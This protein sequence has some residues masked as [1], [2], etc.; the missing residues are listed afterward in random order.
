MS[1]SIAIDGPSGAG[2]S[3]VADELASNLQILHLDTGAMYRAFAWQALAEGID[4]LDEAALIKLIERV[5]I[6]IKFED[7]KQ[8][9]LVNG[10]DVTSLIRTPEISMAASN[11]SRLA[12]V[13]HRMVSLQQAL[14]KT[15][16]MVLDGRD[17]GTR[18]LPDATLKVFLTASPEVRA[19]RRFEE[20]KAKGEATTYQEVLDDVRR[21]DL[22][23]S[24]REVDPLRPAE[25][26][27]IVDNSQL[28]QSQTVEAILVHL[29]KTM[30]SAQRVSEM[31]ELK[32]KLEKPRE[33]P[34]QMPKERISFLYKL[35]IAVASVLF[36]TLFPVRYFHAEKAQL[37]AP[38][39]LIANH[40]SMIDPMI[41]GWKC[42]RYQLRFF[43]KKEL[44]QNPILK[45]LFLGLRM[46]PVDRHN[47]DM[48]AI[49]A[50]LKTLKEG[51][52]LGIFP[53]GT[54]YKQGVM[55][56]VE[57]GVAV[58]ALRGNAP[59]L[60]VYIAGRP[61]LFRPVQC[62]YGDPISVSELAGNGSG[63]ENCEALLAIIRHTY[64]GLVAEHESANRKG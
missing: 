63:R 46:I 8:C 19:K 2:K 41:V 57:S 60:P 4:S 14:S 23:D 48:T 7:G 21:R 27:V 18:V 24:T 22:Q 36:H 53:E 15:C 9:T 52:S 28:S 34:V 32:V 51:H 16:S 45:A 6:E 54:R 43:G 40:N 25:D 44:I 39:I 55:Q 11:V 58:I 31:Q 29:E 62:Y 49:R 56:D 42:R 59:L 37:D 13:R 12:Q 47:M 1:I 3:T 26:A 33:A 38:F 64:Q 50:C 35:A 10:T 30:D 17:I 61:R 5:K 20:L